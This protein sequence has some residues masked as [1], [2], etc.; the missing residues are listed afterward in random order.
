MSNAEGAVL[1]VYDER[2]AVAAKR[3]NRR[4]TLRAR[5]GE[6]SE[7]PDHPLERDAV[8]IVW[9]PPQLLE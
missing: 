1:V 9:R 5:D 8:D 4:L 3:D 2:L 6:G 7:A